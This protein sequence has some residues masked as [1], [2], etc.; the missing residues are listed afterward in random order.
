[1]Q[2]IMALRPAG[3]IPGM[4]YHLARPE[5]IYQLTQ[6]GLILRQTWWCVCCILCF[7]GRRERVVTIS[8]IL[9]D[10]T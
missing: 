7:D 6:I 3:H 5:P 8:G 4:A 9:Q 10:G 1:M 2:C